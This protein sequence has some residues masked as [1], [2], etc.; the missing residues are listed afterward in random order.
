MVCVTSTLRGKQVFEVCTVPDILG[1][2]DEDA[3]IAEQTY[4][5]DELP[6]DL[7]GKL[8]VLNI[9][10]KK[11][12]VPGVGYKLTDDILFVARGEVAQ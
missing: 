4:T 5:E 7:R 3:F 9:T 11:Q 10:E 8:G 2:R 1:F 12:F 6:E